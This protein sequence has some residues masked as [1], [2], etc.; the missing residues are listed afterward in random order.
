MHLSSARALLA[1]AERANERR[2]LV[3]AGDRAAGVRTA[4]TLLDDLP[5]PLSETTLVAT[6]D[7]L[8]CEHVP[9]RNADRLLGTTQRAVVIDLHEDCRPNALGRVVGAVDGGGLLVVLAPPLAEWPTRDG[10]FAAGLAVPPF[11]AA[12]VTGRFRRRLA[13]T[14]RAHPG[15]AIYDVDTDTL[16][17]DGRTRPAPR[18]PDPDPDPQ[19]TADVPAAAIDAC[20]TPDQA[21]ALASFAALRDPGHAVVADADRGRGKSSVAGLAAACLAA[22]GHDVLVTAPRRRNTTE[23]FARA[24][25]LLA[26]LGALASDGDTVETAAGGRI[27][28]SKPPAAAD[29][30]GDPDAVFADEAAAIPV[31][32]LESLLDCQRLAFTTTV[33]GYEGAGRGFD[34]R[35]RDRLADATQTVHETSLTD[36]IRYAGT[37][38]IEPWAFRALLLGARPAVEPLVADATPDTAAYV[39]LSGADLAADE[40][41]LREAFGLLVSAH[42]RTEPNDLARL[43]DAPNLTMRALVA[44]GHVA[45]VALLA[46]EGGLADDRRAAMYDGQRVKGN[47]IPDVLT[48]QLRDEAAATTVG[49]RVLRIATHPAVRSR[50][51]GSRLLG[52]L[53]A[54]FNGH[55]DWL[56]VGY[57]ATPALLSFWAANGYS[58]VHLSTTRNDTSGE[59]SAIMLDALSDAGRALHDRHAGWFADRIGGVL[60][61]ALRDLDADVARGALRACATTPSLALSERD[62]RTVAG[63]AHGP[64]MYSVD[65]RPFR[66]LAVHHLVAGDA[67]LLSP[68]EQRLLV[69]ALLQ[70]RPWDGLADDLGYHSASQAMRALGDALQA[71]VAAHG[72]AAARAEVARFTE[73]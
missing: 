46:R 10:A 42:Y 68:D 59:Y 13:D 45:S 55:A 16:S 44:D 12:D 38:P 3:L 49:Y 53:R 30:P 72:T 27:R 57:G 41:L 73:D 26:D 65:P 33:H 60:S 67:D 54:E 37:D 28:F 24:G 22:E 70:A 50:G 64:G 6:Q 36:P 69:G 20:V 32:L 39:A 8:A 52:E 21:A 63:A 25:A 62:W 34:V 7:A 17:D 11:D 18:L 19:P 23:L 35:F 66:R 4:D 15:I 2:M 40:H 61:D 51:L 43:L 47:M 71:L 29:L 56:G 5:I 14:M 9:T 48:S 31:R 58:T 1:E